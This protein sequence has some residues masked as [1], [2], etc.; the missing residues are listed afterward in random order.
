MK[1]PLYLEA[2]KDGWRVATRHKLLW[3]FG[4]F[5]TFLGQMGIL[6]ILMQGAASA[7]SPAMYPRSFATLNFIQM[8]FPWSASSS[9]EWWS[10]FAW[11]LVVLLSFGL[12]LVF[13]SVVSQ[14]AL[15]ASAAQAAENKKIPDT[16]RAWHIGVDH[17][18]RLLFLNFLKK[19]ALFLAAI[20]VGRAAFFTLLSPEQAVFNSFIFL[21]VFIAA[22]GAGIVVSFLTMYAAGYIVVE[23]YGTLNAIRAAWNLFRNHWLVSFEIGSI[24]LVLTVLVAVFAAFAMGLFILTAK[25]WQVLAIITGQYV[26]FNFIFALGL[27]AALIFL[28]AIGSIFTV[29]TTTVWT[30]LFMKMHRHGLMSK[31]RHWMR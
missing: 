2:L 7:G 13:L 25:V 9:L 24:I 30:H 21:F 23:E 1:E 3:L 15:L 14:G 26:L 11:V 31:I 17:F 22:V 27:F 4:L 28:I 29:F 20:L 10:W 19:L 6:Q 5:A 18:W 8:V 12:L 16:T